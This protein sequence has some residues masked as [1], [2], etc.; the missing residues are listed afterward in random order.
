M[1]RK[2]R[3]EN[4]ALV[5][6]YGEDK[7]GT[8]RAGWI[9]KKKLGAVRRAASKMGMQTLVV[10]GLIAEYIADR[11][12]AARLSPTETLHIREVSKAGFNEIVQLALIIDP[13]CRLMPKLGADYFRLLKPLKPDEIHEIERQ[14][15]DIANERR[16]SRLPSDWKTIKKGS[17]VIANRQLGRGWWEAIVVERIGD[18]LFL[19][20]REHPDSPPA[21]RHR[22]TVALIAPH[23]T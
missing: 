6:V 19:R 21:V 11:I 4:I 20:W 16:L 14:I 15:V 7:T 17:L 18:M 3:D 8:L 10:R 1:S 9:T 5:I 2:N 22:S 13:K 12:A 23:A